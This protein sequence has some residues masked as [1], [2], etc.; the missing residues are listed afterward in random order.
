M[1]GRSFLL[2]FYGAT[3]WWAEVQATVRWLGAVAGQ[4]NSE[5]R[6]RLPERPRANPGGV[7]QARCHGVLP[8]VSALDSGPGAFLKGLTRSV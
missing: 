6:A 5:K 8:S 4:P 2:L 7:L 3:R 1:V